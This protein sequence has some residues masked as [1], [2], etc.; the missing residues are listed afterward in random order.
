MKKFELALA[1]TMALAAS[2]VALAHGGATGIVKERMDGMS[3]MGKAVK[4]L[5]MMMRGEVEY[6]PEQVKREAAVIETHAGERLT[7]LFPTGSGGAPSEAKPT[8]WSDWAEFEEISNQLQLY[9]KALEQAAPNGLM[10]QQPSTVDMMGTTNSGMMGNNSAMMM[11]S[12][13]NMDL[14]ALADMP[15]DGVFNMLAQT[16]A[17]C[18]AKFRIEKK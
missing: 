5:S 4:T 15:A 6:D 14:D 10:M 13:P 17:S 7:S 12:A 16:C 9:A 1:L 8:V 18:H 3:A 2:G 11:G